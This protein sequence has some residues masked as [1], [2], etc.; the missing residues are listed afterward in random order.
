MRWQFMTGVVVILSALAGAALAAPDAAIQS[1]ARG[2]YEGAVE[3]L[4]PAYQAGE[5][6]IQQR[7]LLAR[8]YVHLGRSEEGLVV[9]NSV[10]ETDSENPEANNLKGQILHAAGKHEEALDY[11]KRAYELKQDA[12]TASTLGQCYYAMGDYSKAKTFLEKALQED[13]RNP[14]NSFLLGKICLDRGLGA[15]AE[16]HLLAAQEAGMESLELHLLLGRAYLLQRKF[17]GPV[18]LRRIAADAN[19]GDIVADHV[20]LGRLEGVPEHY[21]T[22]TRYSALYQGYR[23]L[24]A[25]RQHPDGLFMAVSYT[26]LTLPTN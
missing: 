17:T 25:D 2:D 18:L 4:E 21:R 5:A 8:A 7:L 15:L 23:I 6:S 11:L 24:Q 12:A 22:C 20:V 14:D 13:I 1:Y 9:L 16:K 3:Q 26:H 10:L 19:P